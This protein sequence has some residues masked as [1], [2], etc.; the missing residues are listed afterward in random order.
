MNES[1]LIT[2]TTEY[3]LPL[4]NHPALLKR[5]RPARMLESSYFLKSPPVSQHSNRLHPF[6][7][8]SPDSVGNTQRSFEHPTV[9]DMPSTMYL[10]KDYKTATPS[11]SPFRLNSSL[12][13][14]GSRNSSHDQSRDGMRHRDRSSS[15]RVT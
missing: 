9:H 14:H 3:Q 12:Y 13:S 6:L 10:K 8:R 4:G 1:N 5:I 7:T 15:G 2:G 11:P